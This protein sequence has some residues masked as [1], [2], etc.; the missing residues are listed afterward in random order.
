VI[1]CGTCGAGVAFPTMRLFR[2]H[3]QRKHGGKAEPFHVG[4][5]GGPL[6]APVL[7]RPK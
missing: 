3:N 2:R 1:V 6:H 4:G 5:F 7:K